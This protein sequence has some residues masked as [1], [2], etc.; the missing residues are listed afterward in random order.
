LCHLLRL[1]G[2]GGEG[3]F[4]VVS[5]ER[6]ALEKAVKHPIVPLTKLPFDILLFS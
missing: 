4:L 2:V 6:L 1:S 3:S 5:N